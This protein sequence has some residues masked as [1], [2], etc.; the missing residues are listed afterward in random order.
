MGIVDT[1]E[2]LRPDHPRRGDLVSLL[3]GLADA[4]TRVQDPETGLWYQVLDQPGREGNYLE[5]SAS[6]M[7][8]Y[9]LAKA[10]R[11]GLIEP[12]Y[13]DV[14]RRG[15]DGVVRRFI[16]VD[17]QTG[18]VSLADTCQVAGLGG[19]PYRDGSFTY[20]ISE[21]RVS[22]DPKGVAPFILASLEI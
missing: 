7:F 1:L 12:R 6:C 15:Y 16:T 4:I 5:S 10:V 9:A 8:V 2:S 17:P 21:P 18:L 11:L 14:A 19:N 13:A 3:N 20:Y 22:N